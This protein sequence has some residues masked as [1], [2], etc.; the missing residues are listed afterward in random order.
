[1]TDPSTP[2]RGTPPALHRRRPSPVPLKNADANGRIPESP[3]RP[4]VPDEA[5]HKGRIRRRIEELSE[6]YDLR[7]VWER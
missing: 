3:P 4:P 7:E 6:T 2:N 5:A 1:M